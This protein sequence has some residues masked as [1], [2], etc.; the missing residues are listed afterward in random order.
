[1]PVHKFMLFK[2]VV[3]SFRTLCFRVFFGCRGCQSVRVPALELTP[4]VVSVVVVVVVDVADVEVPVVVVSV[5]VD[6]LDL[7]AAVIAQNT[8]SSPSWDTSVG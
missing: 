7:Q 4:V 1:M 6:L 2:L 3:F 8:T 5:V